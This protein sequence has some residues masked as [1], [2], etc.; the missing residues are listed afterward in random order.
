MAVSIAIPF[1]NAE[2]Y[3]ADAIRS[4][5]AQTYQ[6]WE[7]I[8]IDDGS[9]DGSLEIARSVKDPRV[10]VISDGQ[11]KKLAT[12]L[13]EVT[14]LAKYDYIARMDADDL[15]SPSR[16]E[17]QL[18]CFKANPELDIVTTG[19]FSVMNNLNLKGIRG[20]DYYNPTFQEIVSRQKAVT[21]AA[22]IAKKT[23]Y[24]R[25]K[26]DQ[27][28]SIAQDLELWIRASYNNDFKI[29]SISKP[30]YIYRE[31]NNVTGDKLLRA[32][33]NERNMVSKYCSARFR[34]KLLLRSYFKSIVVKILMKIDKV[35]ILQ[36][37][38]SNHSVSKEDMVK[39]KESIKQIR[40]VYVPFQN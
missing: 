25:N 10:R 13:N 4:V 23:W 15:M 39:L 35:G 30:L 9:T 21:H 11:N 3:L 8:L 16:V 38:R 2:K 18:G 7:L 19:V 33:K 32:Y 22:I 17:V 37:R 40:S 14:K 1:Y 6:E 12:R 26:Y 34:Y 24:E 20:Q 27:N 29:M 31:E 5:F 36:K 28:L